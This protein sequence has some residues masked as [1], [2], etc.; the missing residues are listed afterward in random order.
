MKDRLEP[1]NVNRLHPD[2]AVGV[3]VIGPDGKDVIDYTGNGFHTISR[4]LRAAYEAI[5]GN[6][7]PV[8]DYV[9]KVFD[10]TRGTVQQYR[11]NAHGNVHEIALADPSEPSRPDKD[12][13]SM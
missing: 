12:A 1:V 4:A 3:I 11:V 5:P 8:E 10:R 7:L 6:P 13:C 2:D 9:F